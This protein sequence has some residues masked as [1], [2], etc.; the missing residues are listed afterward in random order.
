[1]KNLVKD[2]MTSEVTVIREDREVHELEKLLLQQRIHGVPVVDIHERIIGVVSQTDLLNWHFETGVDGMPFHAEV[3]GGK[4][5]RGLHLSDIRTARVSEIMSPLIHVIGPE[6]SVQEAASRLI[7]ERIHRLIVVDAE[8]RVLGV[9]S[10]L[11]V[12]A[13][14]P[15]VEQPRA[16]L[17]R[18]SP[19]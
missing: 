14:L 15:G 19:D 6:S 1:M 2:L 7:R 11:D 18:A 16:A 3:Q 4:A 10:A 17:P 9:L 13:A 5:A 8:F 12:L